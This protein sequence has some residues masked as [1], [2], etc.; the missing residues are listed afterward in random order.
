MRQLHEDRYFDVGRHYG[1]TLLGWTLG[2]LGPPLAAA[3]LVALEVNTR[4]QADSVDCSWGLEVL[5]ILPV[6]F[7]SLVTVGP[8]AVYASLRRARDPL[9]GSTARWALLLLVPSIPVFLVTGGIA[10]L[11]VPPLGGRALALRRHHA[12]RAPDLEAVA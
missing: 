11:L 3:A 2:V 6:V 9:A 4:C 1:R 8:W 12:A 7:V 5:L 10:F